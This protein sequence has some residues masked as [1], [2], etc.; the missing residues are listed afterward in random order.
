MPGTALW[1][2]GFICLPLSPFIC[3]PLSPSLDAWHGS[4]GGFIC[5]FLPL[6]PS[7]WVDGFIC[8]PL[9]PFIRLPLSPFI[10]LPLSPS[11]DAWHGSLGGRV[12]LSPFVSLH[13]LPFSPS[14]DAWRAWDL[15]RL[16]SLVSRCLPAW[17]PGTALWVDGFTC[18]VAMTS[19][20]HAEGRQFDPGQVYA[21]CASAFAVGQ[22]CVR[23]Q[24][25]AS[26]TSMR[27][28]LR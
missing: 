5:L 23:S 16:P 15:S 22:L 28:Q 13:C 2:D 21:S 11:L 18:L 10:C 4:L 19:A 8:L 12:H 17:M 3:L 6:S 14:L 26:V 24:N 1:V 7:S 27:S 9:S 20:S 25:S